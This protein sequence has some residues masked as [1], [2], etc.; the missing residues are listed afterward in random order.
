MAVLLTI[1]HGVGAYAALLERGLLEFGGQIRRY[2]QIAT[3][4]VPSSNTRRCDKRRQW[5]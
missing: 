3:P 1:L 2:R 5:K 4:R